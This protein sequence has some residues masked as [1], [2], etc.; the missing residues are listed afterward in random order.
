L[1]DNLVFILLALLSG[2]LALLSGGFGGLIAVAYLT[3]KPVNTKQ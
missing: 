2:L 3:N 1:I